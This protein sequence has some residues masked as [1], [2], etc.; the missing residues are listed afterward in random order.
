MAESSS[1]EQ[2]AKMVGITQP[3]VSQL[4]RK[5]VLT[6]GANIVVWMRQYCENL[7]KQAA[8]WQS[9]DGQLDLIAERAR[10]AKRQSEKLEM[11]NEE[12][13]KELLP[14]A[15]IGEQFGYLV[16][17]IRTKLLALPNRFRSLSPQLSVK[18]VD[19]LD[20]LVREIL[21]ELSNERF[22]ADIQT[23][24][25]EYFSTL[26]AATEKNGKP[27]GGPSPDSEPGVK[28]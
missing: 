20:R 19:V 24:I 4:I 11:E 25:D 8:G 16:A 15:A 10:L 21:T 17:T 1:Q 28:R 5:G 9:Q 3:A 14:R 18:Q 26:H 7:R 23:I 12:R 6:R 22:P 2:F 13:R 27:V